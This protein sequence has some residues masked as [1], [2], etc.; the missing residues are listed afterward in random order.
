MC[1]RDSRYSITVHVPKLGKDYN[2]TLVRYLTVAEKATEQR[3][4]DNSEEV[5]VTNTTQR[6]R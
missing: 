2:E 1:I 3:T 5:A 6:S 4:V